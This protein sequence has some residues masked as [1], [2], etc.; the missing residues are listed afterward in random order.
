MSSWASIGSGETT[1][2]HL[3]ILIVAVSGREP[4]RTPSARDSVM[5]LVILGASGFLGKAL[6]ADRHC[7]SCIKAVARRIPSDV[8]SGQPT[9]TWHAADLLSSKS[10]DEVLEPRDIVINL[11][12]APDAGEAENLRLI[13]NVI[14]ACL[15]SRAARLV[16]CSTAVVVG[17]TRISRVVESTPCEP[18]TPYE[19]TKWELEQRVL[20]TLSSGLDVGIV[21]PTAILGPG[22]SNLRKLA[23]SLQNGSAITNYLRACLFG[24]RHMHLVPVRNVAAAVIHVAM[25]PSALGGNV[26]QVSSDDDPANNFH[27]VEGMLRQS[28]GLEPRKLP[29]AP[30]PLQVLGLALRL[31]GRSETNM[32]RLY[33]STKLLATGF[34]PVESVADAV[35]AFGRSAQN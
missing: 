8:D 4:V 35:W 22:G 9:V 14:E 21:R 7:A 27:N 31:L 1:V 10:L 32:A 30:L 28:L 5:S 33:D 24:R 12:Y 26:Y 16:H 11:A 29:L 13:N 15:R 23:D 18:R 6:L 19:K 17:S 3:P 25:L 2:S 20:N 34:A